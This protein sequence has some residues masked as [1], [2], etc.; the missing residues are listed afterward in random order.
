MKILKRRRLEAKTDYKARLTMLVSGKPRL[1]VRKTNRYMVAQIVSSE[2]AQD[3]VICGYS[4]KIL[5]EKGWPKELQG[6]LKTLPAGYLLGL[7]VGKLAKGKVNEVILDIGMNKSIAKSRIYAV[8]E[9]VLDSG[10]KLNCDKSIL[11]NMK[12]YKINDKL[13]SAYEKTLKEV[14]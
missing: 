14:H 8:V 9:G 12:E 6:S 3:K 10:L 1:V 13:K 4:S 11:P 2:I 5:L 7:L